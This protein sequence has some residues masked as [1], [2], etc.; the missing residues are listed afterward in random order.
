MY[1]LYGWLLH[2]VIRRGITIG[3]FTL[4][5]A[6]AATLFESLK[7]MLSIVSDLLARSRE[8]GWP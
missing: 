8:N 3:S 1:S 7:K 5:L 4:Y 2:G 6:S